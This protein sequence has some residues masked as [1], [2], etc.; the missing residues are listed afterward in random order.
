MKKPKNFLSIFLLSVLLIITACEPSTGTPTPVSTLQPNTPVPTDFPDPSPTTA[1]LKS[2]TICTA[3]LPESLLPYHAEGLGGKA[4]I[5]SLIYEA[6]FIESEGELAPVILESVPDQENGNLALVPVSVQAG[7]PVVDATGQLAILKTGLVVR[8]AGCRSGDCVTTWDGE[9]PLE[10]D[11]MVVNYRMREDLTWSDGTAVTSGDSLFSFEIAENAADNE[12]Q[13]IYGRTQTYMAVDQST[14]QW[15]GLPGF[16]NA[17]LARFFWK[18]LPAHLY[19][20]GMNWDSLLQDEMIKTTPIG[21]GPFIVS[22]W[23]DGLLRLTR[24]PQYFRSDEGLPKLDQIVFRQV[25]GA[26]LNAWDAL[27]TGQCDVLDS[28][29][30]WAEAQDVIQEVQLNDDVALVVDQDESWTQLVFGIQPADYDD[31]YNPQ[32]DGRPDILG[33]ART[34]QAFM[35]CLDREGMLEI[36]LGDLGQVWQTYLPPKESQLSEEM[37]ITYDPTRGAELLAQV[38]WVDHDGDPATPLQAWNVAGVPAG[39]PFALELLV[40][41]YNF[42][43]EIAQVI[44]N[45]FGACGVGVNVTTQDLDRLYTP[46]PDGAL[47]GRQFDMALIS[48]Q[49][50]PGGDCQLYQSW[51]VPSDENYWIG[52]NIAGLLNEAYDTACGEAILAL[53]DEV[54]RAMKLSEEIFLTTLPAVPLFSMPKV[55]VIPADSCYESE[56]ASESDFFAN[57]VNFGDCP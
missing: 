35:N 10:M 22:E 7:Q 25:D 11:Q 48:W 15:M 44:K 52:T 36:T 13:W 2:L 32:L 38:G 1:P 8:P 50:T 54:E 26:A 17:D 43:Q 39:T 30:N 4:N 41:P 40:S 6:P 20:D 49:P 45:D 5:L 9:T 16:S 23:E 28:S 53:P 33:D 46:G 56:I 42:H 31:F 29:F 3:A 51:T 12:L 18:P 21:Y 47:F 24:N 34:R 55:M 19:Q 14:V 27:Q 37:K 57:L